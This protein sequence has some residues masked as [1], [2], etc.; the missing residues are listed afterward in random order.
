MYGI[1]HPARQV[2]LKF[3]PS[4]NPLLALDL[5]SVKNCGSGL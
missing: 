1:P 2:V 5:T 3:N 4:M